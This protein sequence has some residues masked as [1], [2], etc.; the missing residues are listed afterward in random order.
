VGSLGV[1]VIGEGIDAGL[2][3]FDCV[4]QV[5]G[6]VEFVPP[7][8]W[9]AFDAS[10]EAWPFGGQDEEFEAAP[11]AFFFEDGFELRAAVDLDAGDFAGRRFDYFAE[12]SLWS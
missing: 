11:L 6:G 1:E 12:K 4:R 10:I 8:R 3:F 7:G 2:P 9:G 5:V